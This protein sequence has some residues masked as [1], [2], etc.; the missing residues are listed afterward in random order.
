M[1]IFVVSGI[2]VNTSDSGAFDSIAP[3][4][5][6]IV[7]RIGQNMFGM[8]YISTDNADA[9]VSLD[10]YNVAYNGT[11]FSDLDDLPDFEFFTLNWQQDGTP[12]VSHVLCLSTEL[13]SEEA[14]FVLSG[15]LLPQF[16]NAKE[17]SAFMDQAEVERVKAA[18]LNLSL[19][20]VPNVTASGVISDVQEAHDIEEADVFIFDADLSHAMSSRSHNPGQPVSIA[21]LRKW[22]SEQLRNALGTS[23]QH[24]DAA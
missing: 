13:G 24:V 22:S 10:D 7:S 8:D 14:M 19:L 20:D 9:K 5:F 23:I 12:Q 21:D 2:E 18:S 15:T 17:F 16:S 4:D 11:H 6:E 3:A 1:T